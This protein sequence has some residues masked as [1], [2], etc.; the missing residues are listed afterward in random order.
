MTRRKRKEP[1]TLIVVSD[2]HCGCRLGLCPPAVPLDDGGVYTQSP[3]QAKL[4]H[5]WLEAWERWVPQITHGEP[6]I[7]VMNGDAVDGK[8][9]DSVT[10][11]SQN[12]EDQA[13]IAEACLRPVLKGRPYY[14]V[15]GTEAHVGKSAQ[16]EE[17]LARSLGAIP[18]DAGQYARWELFKNLGRHIIH[19]QH[20]IGTT[21]SS[22][23]ES[24]AVHKETVEMYV[25]SGR[26]GDDSPAVLVRSHRH[27]C[28]EVRVPSRHGWSSCIVT[29]AW[30]LK[31]PFAHKIPGARV[32]Q[33]Q[34]GLVAVRLGD[35]ELHT[36]AF[37]KRIERPRAE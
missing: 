12:L 28:I 34:I 15:R 1:N 11:I 36:R 24:T 6:Y 29:P 4:W 26:W 25:E 16:N 23:Y 35:E 37:V 33:P 9:H 32:S 2:T 10:Q 27:R 21:G 20:H 17:A 22:A 19:F 5:I 30:Q 7:V 31:T 14:H 8:H 18:N 3:L 13:R